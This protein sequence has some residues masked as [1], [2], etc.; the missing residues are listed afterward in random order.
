M[1][2]IISLFHSPTLAYGSGELKNWTVWTFQFHLNK[3]MVKKNAGKCVA[4][5]K[6]SKAV[7]FFRNFIRIVTSK[8]VYALGK[9]D[10]IPN[11]L[12]ENLKKMSQ[13]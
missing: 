8:V 5:R 9:Y 6:S 4:R 1:F 10:K 12:L 2:T 11:G 7:V 13:L 3:A